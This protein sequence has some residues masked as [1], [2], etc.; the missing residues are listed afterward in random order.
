MT[1]PERRRQQ[2]LDDIMSRAVTDLTFRA[3]LLT[4]PRAAIHEAFGVQVPPHYRLR[5]IEKGL[6]TDAL[7]VLPDPRPLGS[8]HDDDLD[9]VAGGAAAEGEPLFGWW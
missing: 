8:L 3:R 5:F 2:L 1:S 4:E 6:D 7:I 9:A